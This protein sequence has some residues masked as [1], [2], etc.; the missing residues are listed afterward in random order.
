MSNMFFIPFTSWSLHLSLDIFYYPMF[1]FTKTFLCYV[2]PIVKSIHWFSIFIIVFWDFII[3]I[4]FFMDFGFPVK[5]FNLSC[6]IKLVVPTVDFIHHHKPK[7]HQFHVLFC[8][9]QKYKLNILICPTTQHFDGLAVVKFYYD[10]WGS[11]KSRI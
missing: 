10:F 5:Y 11:V 9:C 2:W 7:H 6:V 1:K 3:F 4:L 8:F